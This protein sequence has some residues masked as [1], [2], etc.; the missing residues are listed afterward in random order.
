[1]SVCLIYADDGRDTALSKVVQGY[2][3]AQKNILHI[4]AT[5][6]NMPEAIFQ[7]AKAH[8]HAGQICIILP[9]DAMPMI[10]AQSLTVQARKSLSNTKSV[11]ITALIEAM[12]NPH[13][14]H[15]AG[16]FADRTV[17]AWPQTSVHTMPSEQGTNLEWHDDHL[18]ALQNLPHGI[19]RNVS[20]FA[21]DLRAQLLARFNGTIDEPEPNLPAYKSET[22]N[23]LA[24]H[25]MFLRFG[26][27]GRQKAGKIWDWHR[28]G[29]EHNRRRATALI[30]LD[31]IALR[32]ALAILDANEPGRYINY[33]LLSYSSEDDH[34]NQNVRAFT[35]IGSAFGS[36]VG[37]TLFDIINANPDRE[38]LFAVETD[39]YSPM[40]D[41]VRNEP[42]VSLFGVIEPIGRRL[43]LALDEDDIPAAES[44]ALLHLV[45]DQEHMLH[46]IMQ[47]GSPLKEAGALH[48]TAP[49]GKPPASQ[50]DQATTASQRDFEIINKAIAWDA[51]HGL[52]ERH[53]TL[54]TSSPFVENT[55]LRYAPSAG[56]SGQDLLI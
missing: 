45:H 49:L 4:K 51:Q 30:G 54:W 24:Q 5:S 52:L 18:T 1:M 13:A 36:S 10:D 56:H 14:R 48:F 46:S 27:F 53:S 19:L 15:C 34:D 25:A 32:V 40:L 47:A 11:D 33:G 2:A 39:V 7:V 35:N 29:I 37:Y 8:S 31:P 44:E 3:A 43:A 41:L 12:Q 17:A 55:V 26:K 6:S 20:P 16:V 22:A 9:P 42:L 23:D 28:I 21:A 50:D 38:A